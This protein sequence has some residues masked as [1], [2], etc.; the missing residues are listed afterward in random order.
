[1]D[2]FLVR[3][4][5][6]GALVLDPMVGSGTTAWSAKRL[7]RRCVAYDI[8]PNYLRLASHWL[9]QTAVNPEDAQESFSSNR[10]AEL[11]ARWQA[12]E[13]RRT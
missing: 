8:N 4:S 12:E 5:E 9:D 7:G 6:P 3:A 11:M 10:Q 2:Y 13:S 1:M